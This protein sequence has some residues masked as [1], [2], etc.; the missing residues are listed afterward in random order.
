MRSFGRRAFRRPLNDEEVARYEA[1]AREAAQVWNDFYAGLEFATL[2]MLQSPYF[3]Y[4]REL[5]Q[6]DP[7]D[8]SRRLLSG[9]EIASRLSFFLWS[10]IPDEEL[11][12]AADAG[13][14]W[15]PDEIRAQATRML[16][17]PRAREG[18]VADEPP[19]DGRSSATSGELSRADGDARTG[20]P[21]QHDMPMLLAGNAGG[22][23]R[24]WIHYRSNGE[25]TNLVLFSILNAIGCGL[26][27]F[28]ERS[29]RHD[30]RVTAGCAQI[31]V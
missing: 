30:A 19:Q 26:T 20:L 25:N 11:L 16:E 1:L 24:E 18:L 8:A 29:D 28:G 3:L 21:C 13:K 7:A 22:H 2:A 27:E 4:R 10:S 17:D 31:E 12:D 23:L 14:L 5:G 9:Y 6:P 15:T